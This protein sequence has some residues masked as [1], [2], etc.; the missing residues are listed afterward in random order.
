[1]ELRDFFLGMTAAERLDFARRC[2]TTPGHLR[3]VAYGKP[4]GENLAIAIDRESAGKVPVET[5]RPDCDWA[6]LRGRPRPEAA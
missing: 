6:Y 1:M 3:N 2:R 4:C 5:L